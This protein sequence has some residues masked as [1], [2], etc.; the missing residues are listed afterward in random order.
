MADV[1]KFVGWNEKLLDADVKKLVGDIRDGKLFALADK[2]ML[3]ADNPEFEKALALEIVEA[4][5]K[6]VEQL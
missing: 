2:W 4:L 6:E 5:K 1:R 3:T